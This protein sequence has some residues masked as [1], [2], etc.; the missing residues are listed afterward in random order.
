M[1]HSHNHSH[2]H[3]NHHSV[4]D[5]SDD[6]EPALQS[7]LWKQIEFE[8]ITTLNESQSDAGAKIVEKTWTQRMNPE[9]LLTSDADEQLLMTVPFAGTVKLHSVLVRSSTSDSAPKTLKLFLN[10]DDLDFDAAGVLPPTQVLTLSQTSDIQEV[11]VKRA[12]FGNTYSLTLFFEDNYGNDS[13]EIHYLAFKGDFTKLTRE[14]VEVLY[15][16]AANPRDHTSIVGVSDMAA[17]GPRS[18][19]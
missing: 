3:D 14:P 9:P 8:K 16:K 2:H 5:H 19:M 12:L 15:E 10:R 7:L 18:G 17:S 4:H 1:S 13:T 6:V 11:P